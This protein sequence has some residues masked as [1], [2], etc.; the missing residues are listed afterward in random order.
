MQNW[1]SLSSNSRLKELNIESW[2]FHPAFSD[3]DFI[4]VIGTMVHLT[5]L[6]MLTVAL[7]KKHV[8]EAISVLENLKSLKLVARHWIEDSNGDPPCPIANL[9]KLTSLSLIGHGLGQDARRLTNLVELEFTQDQ[10][11]E[12]LLQ[13]S[14][15]QLHRLERLAFRE[16]KDLA[17]ITISA[18]SLLKNLKSLSLRNSS[19]I[20]VGLFQSLASLPALTEF[21]YNGYLGHVVPHSFI[22]ELTLLKQLHRLSFYGD[23]E[24]MP[25]VDLFAEGSFPRL[26]YLESNLMTFEKDKIQQLFTR[27]PCLRFFD[28][29]PTV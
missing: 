11:S 12:L 16:E 24:K 22:H 8:W 26:M 25:L 15:P 1:T 28:D 4:P 7:F 6:H 14:L 3:F 27:F 17:P 9:T 23:G 18:F 10:D 20:E 21:R 2:S 29:L 19:C 5:S 13:Q